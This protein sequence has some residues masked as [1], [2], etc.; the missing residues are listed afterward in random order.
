MEVGAD[1]LTMHGIG[2]VLTTGSKKVRAVW[3]ILLIVS[4]TFASLFI[5]VLVSEYFE[6][7]TDLVHKARVKRSM[8]FPV[9]T[10]CNGLRMYNASDRPTFTDG[11][12]W[13]K[14]KLANSKMSHFCQFNRLKCLKINLTYHEHPHKKSCLVFNP[15][16]SIH[17]TASMVKN[18]LEIN[19]FINNSDT[20]ESNF[21]NYS[22]KSPVAKIY[23]HSSRVISFPYNDKISAKLGHSTKIVIKKVRTVRQ[24]YPYQSNCTNDEEKKLS[25]FP[26][27]YTVDGCLATIY[28]ID[29]YKTCGYKIAD[30]EPYFPYDKLGPKVPYNQTCF[31]ELIER[32]VANAD[33]QSGYECPLPCH[34]E[35]YEVKA[36][37]EMKYPLDPQLSRF[38]EM[39]SNKM[40]INVSDDYIYSNIGQLVIGYEDFQETVYEEKPKYT[41]QKVLS[42]FGG[43][44]GIY[45]GASFI[46]MAELVAFSIYLI[47]KFFKRLM[48][49]KQ[50]QVKQECSSFGA[51]GTQQI[52]KVDQ[53]EQKEA[54]L[55]V[56]DT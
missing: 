39:F 15:N 49:K 1:S 52:D 7:E 56:V 40:G 33:G 54:A 29:L 48:E 21:D 53:F 14:A 32:G 47:A 31:R 17:Q 50:K 36:W 23:I 37:S 45:L 13:Y 3:S 5:K 27:N 41:A 2:R 11:F 18:G 55:P 26:G 46:S 35:I 16:E 51:A 19:F 22:P 12:E 44:I 30:M 24:K 8:P 34:E 20:T 4:V 28:Q 10:I 25:Y 42:D 43:L 9:V 38:K 6:Y